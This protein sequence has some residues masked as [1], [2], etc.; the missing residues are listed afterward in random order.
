VADLGGRAREGSRPC[1][2]NQKNG[3]RTCDKKYETVGAPAFK[4]VSPKFFSG[5]AV[6]P[7]K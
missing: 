1:Q 4:K 6:A 7:R 2:K 3:L 5:G